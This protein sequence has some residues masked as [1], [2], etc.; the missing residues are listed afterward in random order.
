MVI[1]RLYGLCEYKKSEKGY[2]FAKKALSPVD[3]SHKTV[4]FL[5][6]LCDLFSGNS[7]VVEHCLAKARVAGSNPVS[8]SIKTS[9]RIDQ[10]WTI[11]TGGIFC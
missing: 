10:N 11:A 1:R 9:E 4:K 7:S 6:V 5:P 8:R 2:I 3:F